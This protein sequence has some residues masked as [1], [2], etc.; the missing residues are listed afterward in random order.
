M[1]ID[2]GYGA[3]LEPDEE[4]R[5]SPFHRRIVSATPIPNTRTGNDVELE[6]HHVVKTFGNLDMAAG[7]VLCTQC[8][9]AA[10]GS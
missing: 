8:R 3:Y 6:C 1:K 2:L 7:R 9:D 10:G 4:P 5:S